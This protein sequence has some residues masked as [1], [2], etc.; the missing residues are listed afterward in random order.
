MSDPERQPDGGAGPVLVPIRSLLLADSPRV[1][2]QDEN[3]VRALARF[4]GRLPP[5]VVHRPTM[6]VVDGAHRLRAAL[7]RGEDEIEVNFVD[8]PDHDLFVLAVELNAGQGLPLSRRDRMTAA[9]RIVRTHPTA[10]TARWPGSSGSRRRRSPRS[11]DVQPP[12]CR[13]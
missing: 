13:S 8:G 4:E 10:R 3:H 9:T 12:T 7:H 11:A 5:I 1:A 6:R 2:G